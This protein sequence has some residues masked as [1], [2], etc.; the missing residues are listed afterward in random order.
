MTRDRTKC[1]GCSEPSS[2]VTPIGNHGAVVRCAS[3]GGIYTRW[4]IY[5]GDTYKYVSNDWDPKGS[6]DGAVYYDFIYL[7]SEGVGRRHGWFQPKTK[8]IVQTG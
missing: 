4:P 1:P 5:L 3:C 6:F 2:T 7:G 8:G